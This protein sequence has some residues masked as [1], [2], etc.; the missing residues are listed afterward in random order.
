MYTESDI[1]SAVAAG[2]LAPETAE[3]LREH[4]ERRRGMPAADE[5]H[6]RLLGG[7]N[8]IFVTLALLLVLGF[9]IGLGQGFLVAAVCWAL[10]EYMT[11]RRRLALPSIVLL[12]AFVISL[13]LASAGLF[14]NA[15]YVPPYG[16]SAGAGVAASVVTF[17]ATA[18]YWWRFRVPIAQA[19]M[20]GTV[21]TAVVLAAQTATP[22]ASLAW[23]LLGAGG[24]ATFAYAMW[25]DLRDRERRT[26]RSD[27]A[28][29]LH[30][31]AA[32]L[33]AHSVF[34]QIGLFE[35]ARVEMA[36]IVLAIYALFSLVAIAVDRRAILVSGLAYA[37]AAVSGL[38][39]DVGAGLI[40]ATLLL[41][42]TLLTLG[43]FWAP[44]RAAVL[45]HLPDTWQR[46]L[47]PI[48]RA[49]S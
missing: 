15:G 49:A 27:V 5:E 24:V 18:A 17:A 4:V 37:L 21:L 14:E 28:F 36:P 1:R 45:V 10:A 8:D 16:N 41:G 43:L 31:L 46:R 47:P 30:L 2:I 9:P 38:L 29:W 26:H 40:G 34:G 11:R 7:F 19:A 6:F 42:G 32:P 48:E 3:A 23:P 12:L 25:W 35:A 33:I 44:V 22:D 39:G 13:W 20:A